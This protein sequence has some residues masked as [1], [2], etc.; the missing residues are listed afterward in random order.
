MKKLLLIA[1]SLIALHAHAQTPPPMHNIDVLIVYTADVLGMATKDAMDGV[2]APVFAPAN[3]PFQNNELPYQLRLVG[4][5]A[6]TYKELGGANYS[7]DLGRLSSVSSSVTGPLPGLEGVKEKRDE[8]GADIVIMITA[9]SMPC[10]AAN[11]MPKDGTIESKSNY[12][13][14]LL[15]SDCLSEPLKMTHEVGH[16]AGLSHPVASQPQVLPYWD[17]GHGYISDVMAGGTIPYFSSK[18]RLGPSGQSLGNDRADSEAVLIETLP[19]VEQFR[20]EKIPPG[21]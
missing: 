7:T 19:Q 3:V 14:A 17:N 16:I 6:T 10:G 11:L 18:T 21:C 5:M 13:F 8:L 20:P 4:T 12:G 2:V 9:L 15:R 1:W